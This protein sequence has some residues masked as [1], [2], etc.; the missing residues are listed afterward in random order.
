VAAEI[1]RLSLVVEQ[2]PTPVIITDLDCRIEYVNEAFVRNTGYSREEAI[3]QSPK[4]LKSGKTPV[5]TYDGMWQTLLRGETWQGEFVNQ[6]KGG[7]EQIESAIIVPLREAN[8]RITHYVAIKENI[9]ER[10][11]QEDRLR[12]LFMAVDKARRASSSPIWMPGSN[13]ST[14]ASCARPD[15]PARKRS[16]AIREFSSRV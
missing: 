11:Y 6:T 1:Q 13:T 7:E 2:T 3:G 16:A 8:G 12:K 9:T 15:I 10:K 5:A 4:I 14:R